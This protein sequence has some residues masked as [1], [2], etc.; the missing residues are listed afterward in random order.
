MRKPILIELEHYRCGVFVVF[1]MSAA[2][3]QI[4]DAD[5]LLTAESDLNL[6]TTGIKGFVNPGR[7]EHKLWLVHI[8]VVFC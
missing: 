6:L 8:F 7:L 1:S 5:L 4:S 2:G 3:L